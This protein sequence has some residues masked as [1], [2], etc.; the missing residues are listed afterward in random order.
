MSQRRPHAFTL[1]ELLAVVA[2]C[3]TLV[4]LLLPALGGA[5]RNGERAGCHSNLHQLHTANLAYS[6]DHRGHLAP[7]APEFR[8]NLHRWFGSRERINT[9]FEPRQ[10]PLS[11]HL[12]PDGQVR[13]C[14]SFGIVNPD[15]NVE[16][17][18]GCGGYGY[19]NDYLGTDDIIGDAVGVRMTLIQRPAETIMFTDSAFAIDRSEP[20]IIEYSF[21]TPP[22]QRGYPDRR[23]APSIHF[24]HGKEASVAWADGH[25]DARPMTFTR[26]N[27]Y[28]IDEAAMNRLQIGFPG[29]DDNRLFDLE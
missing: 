15:P 11:E 12:G 29:P 25:I 28:G 4:A 10:G 16:F 19:N 18:A 22:H 13:R 21:A 6:L 27:I 23:M 2:I 9:A 7:G 5:R 8:A 3:A 24:R 14:P 26:S 17:E 1:I 20:R